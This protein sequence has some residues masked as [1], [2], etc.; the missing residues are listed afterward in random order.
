MEDVVN[1]PSIPF[2]F[3]KG[4]GFVLGRVVVANALSSDKSISRQRTAV[5]S[6]VQLRN[7]PISH[8]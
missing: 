5:Q 4:A 2:Q 6:Q 7:R 3:L 8:G 1:S